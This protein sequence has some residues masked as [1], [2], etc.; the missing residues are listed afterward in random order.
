ML[1]GGLDR[2][3][4]Q[5]VEFK[6]LLLFLVMLLQKVDFDYFRVAQTELLNLQRKSKLSLWVRCLPH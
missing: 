2:Q 4:D 6:L 3:E 5:E 1:R